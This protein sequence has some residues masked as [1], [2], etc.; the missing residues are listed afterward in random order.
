MTTGN[1]Q[2]PKLMHGY[3]LTIDT[4]NR[5][6]LSTPW[7]T[8]TSY[9]GKK[10]TGADNPGYRLKI[11]QGQSAT[12]AYTREE[13]LML[14]AKPMR[15]R[16]LAYTK[17]WNGFNLIEAEHYGYGDPTVPS[18]NELL[19]SDLT[20]LTMSK[21]YGVL[22]DIANPVNGLEFLAE[23]RKSVQMIKNP[24]KSLGDYLNKHLS[25]QVKLYS[26]HKRAMDSIHRVPG[27][28]SKQRLRKLT[29]EA[30]RWGNLAASLRLEYKM[31]WEPLVKTVG[32]AAE[33]ATEAF[34]SK[35]I[36]RT[37]RKSS[38]KKV[39]STS[40]DVS[41]AGRT[42]WETHHIDEYE[43]KVTLVMRVRYSGQY[44]GMGELDQLKARSGFMKSQLIPLAWE[45]A[46]LSVFADYFANVGQ[47]L[48]ASMTDTKDVVSVDRYVTRKL[49]RRRTIVSRPSIYGPKD[50]LFEQQGLVVAYSGKYTREKWSMSIPPLRF[51]TPADSMA[52]TMNLAAFVKLAFFK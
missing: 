34:P 14:F 36:I 46:P 26:Q 7:V 16:C 9:L 2:R 11:E 39:A 51:T 13:N 8:F 42:G 12:N 48:A 31:G 3:E 10:W 22:Q 21:L 27:L 40:Y 35:G 15:T 24:A 28:T 43:Y 30:N 4:A 38:Y 25:K 52:Q 18:W 29:R 19:V 44:D 37:F 41:S 17:P 1:K 50:P 49:L 5:R 45:L 33:A 20:N 6:F 32:A 23:F 47:I